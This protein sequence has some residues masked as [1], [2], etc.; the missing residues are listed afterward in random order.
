[1]SE[2][3]ELRGLWVAMKEYST[4]TGL[5]EDF[6]FTVFLPRDFYSRESFRYLNGIQKRM[7]KDF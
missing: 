4:H 6:I 2:T 1:M 5:V 7:R 3:R